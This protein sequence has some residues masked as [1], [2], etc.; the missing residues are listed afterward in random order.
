[1]TFEQLPLDPRLL[2]GIQE[3]GFTKLTPVQERTLAI[4]L[5]GLDAAVQS[6]TGTGKTAAFLITIFQGQLVAEASRRKALI[7]APTRELAVQIEAEAKLIGRYLSASV[8]CFYGGVGYNHQELMLKRGVDIMV[9]TPGRLLDLEQKGT[10]SMRD[11]GFLVIDEA[12]RL[13][14]MGFLPDIR[15]ILRRVPAVKLR[16]TM[17]FSATLSDPAIRLAREY[18]NRPER[19][20]ITPEQITVDTISQELYHVGSREKVSLLLGILKRDNPKSVLFFTNMKCD[21]ERLA[22]KLVLNGYRC[23]FLTGDLPQSRRLRII[24][25]FK[26]GRVFFLVATDVAARGLHI[27]DLD[28]VVNFDLPADSENYVHRIGRTARA[29]KDG[30]AVSLACEKYVCNLDPIEKLINMKIPSIFAEEN[31]F[32]RDKSRGMIFKPAVRPRGPENRPK[33][34]GP[35]HGNRTKGRLRPEFRKSL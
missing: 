30:K 32:L 26:S 14:D 12:D 20:E 3:M 23:E 31:L 1:M 27:D 24:N 35:Q 19:I 10:L 8:G 15:K 34:P 6:Q 7:I 13:F 17:L 18:M 5:T 33:R 25:D 22:R 28:M 16:Q 2:R 9:G 21:A 29:G 4:T 11:I